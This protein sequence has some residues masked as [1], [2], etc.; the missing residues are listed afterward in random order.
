MYSIFQRLSPGDIVAEPFPH[1]VVGEA[2][3]GELFAALQAAYPSLQT[4]SGRRRFENNLAYQRSAR[5][6]V[7]GAAYPQI[8]REF[9]A[10]HTS[11][12]FHAELAR[13]WA[14]TIRR[15]Y[16]KLEAR[17][18]RPV[19]QADVAMRD[20]RQSDPA[21]H[22]L[23]YDCQFVV[24]SPVRAES[25][26]RPPH[27]DSTQT[28]VAALLYFRTPGDDSRGGEL[29]MFTP[30]ERLVYDQKR[31]VPAG[32]LRRFKTVPYAANTLVSWINSPRSLHGVS[33]RS[34]TP[35]TRQY[36]N[37]IAE[38]YKGGA[39]FDLPTMFRPE[40]QRRQASLPRRMASAVARR[41]RA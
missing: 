25:S 26:V 33:P 10:F 34:V 9:F 8:W 37:V 22:D 28:L 5:D 38:C 7:D 36:V 23:V 14:D 31:Q 24:N 35:F 39:L 29:E 2:L 11:A 17:F 21:R 16:P 13:V 1:I 4:V 12:A 41:L 27:V 20:P 19:E 18:G 32:S 30:T 15:E 40:G 6:V 3:P